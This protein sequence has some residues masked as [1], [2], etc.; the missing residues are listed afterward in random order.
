MKKRKHAP[1]DALIL[2]RPAWKALQAK[3][4]APPSQALRRFMRTPTGVSDELMARVIR[5]RNSDPAM[6]KRNHAYLE[7]EMLKRGLS[8][9]LSVFPRAVQMRLLIRLAEHIYRS[10]KKD[11]ELRAEMKRFRAAVRRKRKQL[12]VALPGTILRMLN[13]PPRPELLALMRRP[14]RWN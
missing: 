9:M 2:S 14:K 12:S 10:G 8:G 5:A 3:L 13:Q 11:P 1:E 6:K 4:D 7:A